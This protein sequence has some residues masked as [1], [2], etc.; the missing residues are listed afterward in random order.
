M[1]KECMLTT[2]DNPYNPFDDF[3]KWFMYD[4]DNA[5]CYK[6][7]GGNKEGSFIYIVKNTKGNK[8]KK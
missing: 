8:K 5:E 6:R 1:T 4:I 7:L 2:I 3:N